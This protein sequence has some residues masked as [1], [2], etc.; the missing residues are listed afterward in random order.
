MTTADDVF[1]LY[2]R[3]LK[4]YHQCATP[5]EECIMDCCDHNAPCVLPLTIGDQSIPCSLAVKCYIRPGAECPICYDPI[6]TKRSAFITDCG[7]HFHK[8][9]MFTYL[10]TKWCSTRYISTA[11]C[12]MCR[13]FLGHPDIEQRY[14]AT[15]FGIQY[16]GDSELDKL[17]D[18][19][20]TK[21]YKLPAFCSNQYDH[22]LGMR[23]DCDTCLAYRQHGDIMYDVEQ[24]EDSLR[25]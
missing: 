10:E 19:W 22:Y 6:L 9:C 17:E 1:Y 12:P 15:Y 7:H 14:R 5:H 4:Y 21:D 3:N 24:P 18:F 8:Q 23:S 25:G 2:E 13:S 20:L 11:R 16:R